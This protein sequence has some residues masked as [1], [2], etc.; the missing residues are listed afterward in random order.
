MRNGLENELRGGVNRQSGFR[1]VDAHY[2]PLPEGSQGYQFYTSVKP[3]DSGVG[4]GDVRWAEGTP[5]VTEISEDLV[6][7]PIEVNLVVLAE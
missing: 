6:A 1:S 3:S 4:T 7:I 5:G 2:G